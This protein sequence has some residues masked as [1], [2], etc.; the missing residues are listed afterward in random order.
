MTAFLAFGFMLLIVA[1]MAV[2][3]ILGRK[4]IQGSCGGLAA[5]GID[6]ECEICGGR[7]EDCT[8]EVPS[9]PPARS[10]D[11]VDAMGDSSNNR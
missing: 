8:A 11:A 7:P 10:I 9:S 5:L 6:G 2:G 3:V 4:P 1:A